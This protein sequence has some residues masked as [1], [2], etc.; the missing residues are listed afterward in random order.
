MSYFNATETGRHIAFAEAEALR[1][2]M[3]EQYCALIE[4]AE[5]VV[6]EQRRLL[7]TPTGGEAARRTMARL[8][9]GE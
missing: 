3:L 1:D 7:P 8:M 2:R 4:G 5:R 6:V 9:G